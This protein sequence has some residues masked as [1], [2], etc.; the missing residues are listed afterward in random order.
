MNQE[1]SETIP[2]M[3]KIIALPLFAAF[4]AV[5]SYISIPVGPVP[6]AL[7]NFFVVLAGL[8]L[9]PASGAAAA[10]LFL[11]MGLVGLPVYVGGTGGIAHFAAPTAGYLAAYP[12]VAWLAGALSRFLRKKP[13][14]E[15]PAAEDRGF[16]SFCREL[17][18]AL[19]AD[20][21]LY[22]IGV[23]WLKVRLGLDWPKAI[24]LGLLPFII[25][26]IIKFLAAALLA[27]RLRAIFRAEGIA[28]FPDR[29]GADAN[30][31]AE[32][33]TRLPE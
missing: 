21:L 20:C 28:A 15:E 24:A 25:G 17:A 12:A 23:S 22:L 29:R 32:N 19:A 16:L 8:V 11:F 27:P 30:E 33:Q 4:M 26:D 10:G 5:G 18:A 9:G 3:K 6:I 1:N 7:Q 31:E 13:S 2:G 14:A